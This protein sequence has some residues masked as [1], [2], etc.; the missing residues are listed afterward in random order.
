MLFMKSLFWKRGNKALKSVL[1]QMDL[2]TSN[3]DPVFWTAP[4]NPIFSSLFLNSRL[5][6]FSTPTIE[7]FISCTLQK[8]IALQTLDRTVAELSAFTTE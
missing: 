7:Q 4:E 5:Y 1:S 8:L 3:Y 6:V 2:S